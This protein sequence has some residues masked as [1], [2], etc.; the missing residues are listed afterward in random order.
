MTRPPAAESSTT[1][2]RASTRDQ[3]GNG[4]ILLL[5]SNPAPRSALVLGVPD[6][7]LARLLRLQGAAVVVARNVAELRAA[8]AAELILISGRNGASRIQHDG[9]LRAN[10]EARV[11]D[12]ATVLAERRSGR[13]RP[14]PQLGGAAPARF[15]LHPQR[16]PVRAAH[17]VDD[18]VAL[19]WLIAH[20]HAGRGLVERRA[21]AAARRFRSSLRRGMT[22]VRRRPA[23]VGAVGS[24]TG[25]DAPGHGVV[26][27]LGRMLG[28]V[29]STGLVWG[30]I[31]VRQLD[32]THRELLRWGGAVVPQWL[33]EA[34]ASHPDHLALVIPGDFVTQ[35]LLVALFSEKHPEP[36]VI[37]KLARDPIVNR[38]VDTAA[39]ALRVL[40]TLPLGDHPNVPRLAGAGRIGQ[41][42]FVAEHAVPG[43][44][45]GDDDEVDP[46]LRAVAA[47]LLEIA[48]ASRHDVA[49]HELAATMAEH[50]AEFRHAYP[51]DADAAR[52][53]A[54]QVDII[55][56]AS[57]VPLVLQHG[58]PGAWNL[59]Q[60]DPTSVTL[61]DW[62][63]ADV[64]GIPIADLAFLLRSAGVVEA[65]QRSRSVDRLSASMHAFTDLRR[66]AI[67]N[68]LIR[69][70]ATAIDL[71]PTLIGPLFYHGWVLQAVREAQR[72]PPQLAERGIFVRSLRR[73]VV[74]RSHPQLQRLLDTRDV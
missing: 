59:L 64:H 19:D 34:T 51:R 63:N 71:E 30:A 33:T 49:G 13:W 35:K 14:D 6:Q 32:R 20:A 67:G 74:G 62:E 11:L 60:H 22:I 9:E 5:A 25:G 66:V 52:W 17:A 26:S 47:T 48:V 8:G 18:A 44:P 31:T 2:E 69:E 61:I 56:A 68:E 23:G 45:P 43:H 38:R 29:F 46:W 10:L 40:G 70:L 58:D 21:E 41:L 15:E 4:G 27:R 36:V 16:G 37:L 72:L 12:G 39:D 57:R 28:Q 53:L 54:A 1:D 73:L 24:S 50:L 3:L 7:G 65:R 55:A 42:A